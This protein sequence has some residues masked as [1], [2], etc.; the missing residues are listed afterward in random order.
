MA[1]RV[2]PYYPRAR[3]YRNEVIHPAFD[4]EIYTN[5]LI[6]YARAAA[7]ANRQLTAFV[8]DGFLGGLIWVG[9]DE[10]KLEAE[11]DFDYQNVAPPALICDYSVEWVDTRAGR[12]WFYSPSSE[13]NQY[14]A[15]ARQK[16]QNDLELL[17][18]K[19]NP[20]DDDAAAMANLQSLLFQLDQGGEGY[21]ETSFNW[22][23]SRVAG[24]YWGLGVANV[25][26]EVKSAFAITGG[27]ALT[28]KRLNA[29]EGQAD[30]DFEI[31]LGKEYSLKIGGDG[32]SSEF[33]HYRQGVENRAALEAELQ[34]IIDKGRLTPADQK[35]ILDWQIETQKVRAAAKARG[36]GAST[37]TPLETT[38]IKAIE[39]K[40]SDLKES[41]RGNTSADTNRRREIEDKLIVATLSFNLQSA[42]RSLLTL[43]V[44][45]TFIPLQSGHVVIQVGNERKVYEN[46]EWQK[47]KPDDKPYPPHTLGGQISFKSDG[48]KWGLLY[49]D[50]YHV[51]GT[52][53]T[54]SFPI[55][56]DFDFDEVLFS[57]NG[58]APDNG[59]L[60]AELVQVRAP[61]VSNGVPRDGL[62]QV[63]ITMEADINTP[64]FYGLELYIPAVVSD[65]ET[66]HW[67]SQI[68][69]ANAYAPSGNR[70]ADLTLQASKA[71]G[72]LSKLHVHNADNI[73]NLLIPLAGLAGDI[74]LV[75][76]TTSAV[77]VSQKGGFIGTGAHPALENITDT[78][79]LISGASSIGDLVEIEV[80]GVSG[81]LNREIKARFS[82]NGLFV[83]D[84][85]RSLAR[86]GGLP[87]ARYAGI[88]DTVIPGIPQIKNGHIG[89]PFSVKPSEGAKYWEWMLQ[90]VRDHAPRW[91]LWENESGL[92]FT[93]ASFRVRS[94]LAYSTAHGTAAKLAL[95]RKPTEAGGL[96]LRQDTGDYF[97]GATITGA[98][99][100]LTGKRFE[101]TETIPQATDSRF[102]DSMFYTGVENHYTAP[103]NDALKSDADC[104]LA[105]RDY[106]NITPLTPQG[107]PPWFLDV[108]V[109]FDATAREGDLVT[110]NG[111]KFLMHDINFAALNAGDG[112]QMELS[113]RLASDYHIDVLEFD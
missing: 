103:S 71:R 62:Y 14:R 78:S 24:I 113:L 12:D 95:R 48:G 36:T 61:D 43:A 93:K 99:N 3:F 55:P 81:F 30:H 92:Q 111:I 97:T 84:A 69:A 88:P 105:A 107:L 29:P 6:A 47:D 66:T 52:V 63:K 49:G 73:S 31:M 37:L 102:A 98:K 79:G 19:P 45:I 40:I 5:E 2:T 76:S 90:I 54:P 8:E 18:A 74:T 34:T 39:K 101:A 106:L 35:Q 10:K 87:L 58:L 109:D 32:N 91:D 33:I 20:S 59:A 57:L 82:C 70:I 4:Y 80:G 13:E 53:S 77:I 60:S 68:N 56:F 38:Q 64:E 83:N 75:D 42:A 67:D 89:Q 110:C 85:L 100:P 1:N 15:L 44:D 7:V 11:G 27:V 25:P 23:G 16:Y 9:I 28:L 46:K 65:E 41:K 17:L 108:T 50:V 96:A 51:P 86:D 112:A 72:R 94:D 22:N 104:R 26:V 21:L